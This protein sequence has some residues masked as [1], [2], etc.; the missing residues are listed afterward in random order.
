MRKNQSSQGY[1]LEIARSFKKGVSTEP[2]KS[3]KQLQAESE[4]ASKIREMERA[5][6]AESDKANEGLGQS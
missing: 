6:R 2:R 3:W 1:S 5:A 4:A